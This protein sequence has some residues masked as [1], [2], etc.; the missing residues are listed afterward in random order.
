M[1][2]SQRICV[3]NVILDSIFDGRPCFQNFSFLWNRAPARVSEPFVDGKGF[4]VSML[5]RI[6]FSYI[7]FRIVM[8]FQGSISTWFSDRNGGMN[9][10]CGRRSGRMHKKTNG[11]VMLPIGPYISQSTSRD[12]CPK[13][14]H[15][16][17]SNYTNSRIC[18]RL[19]QATGVCPTSQ[20]RC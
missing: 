12:E 10:S 9:W 6:V 1:G 4:D 17:G 13:P 14:Q 18:Y 16:D 20:E 5:F 15:P 3:S 7:V 8:F 2:G 11:C 19:Q